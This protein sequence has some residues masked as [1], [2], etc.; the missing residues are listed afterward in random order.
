MDFFSRRVSLMKQK[1]SSKFS[2]IRLGLESS[3]WQD[4][5]PHVCCP[6]S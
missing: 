2:H 1:D 5:S 4:A 3:P 6:M